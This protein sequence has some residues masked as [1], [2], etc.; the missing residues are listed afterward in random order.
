MF[1]GAGHANVEEFQGFWGPGFRGV[2]LAEADEDDRAE[3]QAFAALD[4][5]DVDLRFAGVVGSLAGA[6]RH[7][8]VGDPTRLEVVG[9]AFAVVGVH[10][11]DGD[12]A[13]EITAGMPGLDAAGGIGDFV[14]EGGELT[15]GGAGT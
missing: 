4:S 8:E 5:E 14:G 13:K 6:V 12:L 2:D 10:A 3:F 15:E 9:D 11:D 1:F 7:E